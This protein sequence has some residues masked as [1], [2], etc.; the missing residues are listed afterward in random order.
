MHSFLNN[1]ENIKNSKKVKYMIY[2]N[3]NDVRGT[4]IL[5]YETTKWWTT[6]IKARSDTT[7]RAGAGANRCLFN[8]V[9]FELIISRT[10][11][12]RVF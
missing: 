3:K 4:D 7:Q 1:L 10:R 9:T 2:I 6:F 11:K 12:I 8:L 5:K